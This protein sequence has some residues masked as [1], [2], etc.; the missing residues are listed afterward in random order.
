MNGI[1]KAD[2]PPVTEYAEKNI[3]EF[4]LGLALFKKDEPIGN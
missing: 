4:L 3:A 2:S 1:M